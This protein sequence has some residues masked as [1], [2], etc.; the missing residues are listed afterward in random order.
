MNENIGTWIRSYFDGDIEAEFLEEN[1][2]K[3]FNTI[4]HKRGK[5]SWLPSGSALEGLRFMYPQISRLHK[6]TSSN[7]IS[8][9]TCLLI[10]DMITMNRELLEDEG[11]VYVDEIESIG[12]IEDLKV[13]INSNT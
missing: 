5:S 7:K 8:L 6:D 9:I 13:W 10:I 2:S 1:I 3:N 11:S 4:N 12:T